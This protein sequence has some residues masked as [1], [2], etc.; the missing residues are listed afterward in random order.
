MQLVIQPLG[1]LVQQALQ[2]R[3]GCGELPISLQGDGLPVPIG[4]GPGRFRILFEL[5]P[6]PCQGI[7]WLVLQQRPQSGLNEIEVQP[8]RNLWPRHVGGA[9]LGF[10]HAVDRHRVGAQEF[11]RPFAAGAADAPDF[12]EKIR[13]AGGVVTGQGEGL[14]ADAIRFGFVGPRVIDVHLLR[15]RLTAHQGSRDGFAAAASGERYGQHAQGDRDGH[16]LGALDGPVQVQLG[17]VGDFMGQNTGDLVLVVCR[18]DQAA[19][20]RDD[21]A[22]RGECVDARLV[23]DHEGEWLLR[24][25]AVGH[26][27]ESHVREMPADEGVLHQDLVG[28]HLH[29]YGA[30]VFLLL[31]IGKKVVR[32]IAQVWQGDAILLRH[33]G[34]ARQRDEKCKH[35]TPCAADGWLDR[36]HSFHETA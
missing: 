32:R 25:V 22:R 12:L 18:Q 17:D 31:T 20:Q 28:P 5:M 24:L 2:Q 15:H 35:G 27:P 6:E 26:Q 33:G 19:V 29:E 1:I 34:E 21:A 13:H 16:A 30:G 23:D 36:R 3:L 9:V 7:P 14:D 11:G 10:R 4:G 8:V